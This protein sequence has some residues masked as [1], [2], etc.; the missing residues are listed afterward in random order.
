EGLYTSQWYFI[1]DLLGND[2][3]KATPLLSD[4]VQLADYSFGPT[5]PQITNVWRSLY[6]MILRAN[7]IVAQ[8]EQLE[9]NTPAEEALKARY[10]AEVRF[11]RALAYFNLNTLG[12]GFRLFPITRLT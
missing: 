7:V 9:V 2:V 5:Q 1:F 11:L 6:R 10:I 8:A 12:E 3:G 4:L